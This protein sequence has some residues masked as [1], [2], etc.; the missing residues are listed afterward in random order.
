VLLAY[1]DESFSDDWYFMAVESDARAK[2]ANEALWAQIKPIVVHSH[3][4]LP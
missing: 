1:V 4:W 2:R 3:C